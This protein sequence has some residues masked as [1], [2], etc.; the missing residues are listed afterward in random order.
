MASRS[1]EGRTHEPSRRFRRPGEFPRTTVVL[2]GRG[3]IVRTFYGFGTSIQPIV[4]AVEEEL[5]LGEIA[6][7]R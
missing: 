1:F 6:P 5:D 2:D 7:T 4:D 3:R